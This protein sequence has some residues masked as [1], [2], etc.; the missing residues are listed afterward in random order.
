[1]GRRYENTRSVGDLRNIPTELNQ[2][3][4]HDAYSIVIKGK[5]GTGKTALALTILSQ[6]V[7]KQ[8]CLYI[9]SRLSIGE[10]FQYYPWV[11]EFSSESKR[12][13]P[14]DTP[15][16]SAEIAP[17]VDARLDEPSALFERI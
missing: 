17:F 1:M 10:L 4:E 2:F 5:A 15:D 16:G 12:D 14:T 13:L 8:P 6:S 9:S 11:N 3:L 7:G